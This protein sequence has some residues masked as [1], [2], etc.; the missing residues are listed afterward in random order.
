MKNMINLIKPL[1]TKI[2]TFIRNPYIDSICFILLI[3]GIRIMSYFIS[4]FT[5]N[6]IPRIS[7]YEINQDIL[8]S[9]ISIILYA[10]YQKY[11]RKQSF[12][13]I[14][15][16]ISKKEIKLIIIGTIWIFFLESIWTYYHVKDFKIIIDMWKNAY[17]LASK[18]IVSGEIWL[19]LSSANILRVF[20]E[21]LSYAFIQTKMMDTWGMWKGII[22]VDSLFALMHFP[23]NIQSIIYIF[24]GY[25]FVRYLF[26]KNRCILTPFLIHI[27]HNLLI[28]MI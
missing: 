5:R 28:R 21:E 9:F 16:Q 22:I 18:M 27:L 4:F 13:R 1:K 26:S 12:S 17:W 14:G 10:L 15:F 2:F 11:I 7:N 8:T 23:A 25:L 24:I 19:I 3:L 20:L 6:L